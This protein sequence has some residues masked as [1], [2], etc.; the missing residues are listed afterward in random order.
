MLRDKGQGVGGS[1]A[2]RRTGLAVARGRRRHQCAGLQCIK[3]RTDTLPPP[4]QT[5]TRHRPARWL[6]PAPILGSGA[7]FFAAAL[8]I[9]NEEPTLKAAVIAAGPVLLYYVLALV[10]LP[11][12]FSRFA[13]QYMKQHPELEAE[14]QVEAIESATRS[15]DGSGGGRD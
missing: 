11:K 7:L 1:A 13:V 8:F 3:S 15:Q 5:Q 2:G 14:A 12:S 10:V 4:V 9:D 6:Q